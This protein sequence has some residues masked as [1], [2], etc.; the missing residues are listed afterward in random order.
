[1]ARLNAL[2]EKGQPVFIDFTGPGWANCI[3]NEAVAFNVK[4]TKQ[5]FE[6]NKIVALRADK[7]DLQLKKQ[8]E[9]LFEKLGHTTKTIPYC[10]FFPPA[11]SE[12]EPVGY[13]GLITSNGVIDQ[14]KEILS[15]QKSEAIVMNK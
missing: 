13:S 8:I 11:R 5:Y 10:A 1:M 2:R 6:E 4:N 9:D 12:A 3:V 15:E 14:F 7:G